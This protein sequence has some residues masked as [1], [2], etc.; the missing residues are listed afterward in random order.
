MI[1]ISECALDVHNCVDDEV[2]LSS[3][4]PANAAVRVSS[5]FVKGRQY[6]SLH[7]RFNVRWKFATNVA[8]KYKILIE[9]ASVHV[10][11]Y[12]EFARKSSATRFVVATAR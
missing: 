1:Y 9:L 11:S 7:P 12:T 3:N 10:P 5:F 2:K 8:L 6:H 4:F